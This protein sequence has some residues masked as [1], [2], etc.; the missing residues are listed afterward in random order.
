MKQTKIRLFLIFA[1][2]A[3]ALAACG[4]NILPEE[5]S[6]IPPPPNLEDPVGEAVDDGNDGNDGEETAVSTPDTA[7][8]NDSDSTPITEDEVDEATPIA[9]EEATNTPE[10]T[11]TLVPLPQVETNPATETGTLANL[12]G[13][14]RDLVFIG[15]GALKLLTYQN[16]QLIDLYPGGNP[17]A[18]ETRADDPFRPYVGDITHYDISA[19]GNRI[20]AARVTAS[21]ELTSTIQGTDQIISLP[22][23][24]H[25]VLFLDVVSKE[26]WVL[27]DAVTDLQTV[28]VAPNQ[29]TVAF[30]G[31]S[32]SSNPNPEY[33]EALP[34]LNVYTVLT[35]DKGNLREIASCTEFCH[36]LVWH[37]TSELFFYSDA[38]AL[39]LYNLNSSSPQTLLQNQTLEP[40]SIRV[41]SPISIA[42]NGRFLLMWEGRLEGG[43]RAVFD[44]P[45]QQVIA[46]PDS[47]VYADPFPTEVAW[48]PDTRL[49]VIRSS[50]SGNSFSSA[51]EL[52]RIN[53]DAG[54]INLE[55]TSVPPQN[56]AASSAMNLENG[57]FAYALINPNSAESSG[58][59]L[60]TSLSE[61]NQRING[62]VPTFNSP[63]VAWSPDGSSAVFLQNGTP[64]F[65]E[66]NGRLLDMSSVFG[67]VVREFEWLPETAVAR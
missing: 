17:P 9:E 7:E 28:T 10:P 55:E 49:L 62:V 41:Y 8:E 67:S 48:M 42:S 52:W 23:I 59:Y 15:D 6:P 65:A 63:Q 19:D 37:P 13:T 18:G 3:V 14:T 50:V 53:V 4:A 46:V 32:L 54:T 57:R 22:Y 24:E 30:I 5:P 33:N 38:S 34:D 25:E 36:T 16:K 47:F 64:Y 26:T 56:A 39:W 60:Q 35:P 21:K 51:L 12:P 40:S 2:V 66:I 27:A 1:L 44:I 45:T 43:S 58:L 61:P 11:P 31:S 29:Q 20:V